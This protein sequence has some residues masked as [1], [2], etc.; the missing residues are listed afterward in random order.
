MKG[1]T[2]LRAAKN[3]P[4]FETKETMASTDNFI[5]SF[6]SVSQNMNLAMNNSSTANN[7][8]TNKTSL[9]TAAT[10]ANSQIKQQPLIKHIN[11]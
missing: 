9:D 3:P 7:I 5:G 4:R 8:F 1:T 6:N 2:Q 11:K 10:L